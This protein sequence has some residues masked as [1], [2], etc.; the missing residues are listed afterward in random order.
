[1]K[2]QQLRRALAAAAAFIL[3]LAPMSVQAGA[4]YPSQTIK[5]IVPNPAGGLPD[6]I[7]ASSA[8]GYKSGSGRPWSSRTGPVPTRDWGQQL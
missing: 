5:L 7:T 6:T 4:P 1:M 2:S 8:V 3:L